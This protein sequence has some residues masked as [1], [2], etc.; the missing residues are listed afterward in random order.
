MFIDYPSWKALGFRIHSGPASTGQLT[1]V[2]RIFWWTN[3]C[4]NLKVIIFLAICWLFKCYISHF[5][6][7]MTVLEHEALYWS[8]WNKTLLNYTYKSSWSCS[9]QTYIYSTENEPNW[10]HHCI[11]KN[12][13][14][15]SVWYFTHHQNVVS[16][17]GD[18][19]IWRWNVAFLSPC[20]TCQTFVS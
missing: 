9:S 15:I 7:I 12:P 1:L 20:Q 11:C 2:V 10:E 5:I 4:I 8:F 19:E 3:S 18:T 6:E 14:C 17:S 13:P 16:R